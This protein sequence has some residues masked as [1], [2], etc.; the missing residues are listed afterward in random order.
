M[1]KRN[2]PIFWLENRCPFCNHSAPMVYKPDLLNGPMMFE[3]SSKNNWFRRNDVCYGKWSVA[4]EP[5]AISELR[6]LLALAE[7]MDNLAK[8]IVTIKKTLKC[9]L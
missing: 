1:V 6:N 4:I 8:E 2:E 5:N 9:R 3:C 7:R